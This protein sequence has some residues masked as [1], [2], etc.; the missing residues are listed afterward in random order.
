MRRKN[1]PSDFAGKWNM[2][3][4]EFEKIKEE[5]KSR[6]KKW[7]LNLSRKRLF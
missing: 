5:L 2:D 7:K 6:W 3:E 1:K 4:N